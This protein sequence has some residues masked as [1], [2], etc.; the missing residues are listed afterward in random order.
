MKKK[1]LTDTELRSHW[2]GK[3]E[4]V[5][6][7]EEGTI[8]TP[9]ARDFLREHHITLS[10][11]N[12]AENSVMTRTAIPVRDGKAVYVNAQTGRELDQKGE[13]MTHLRGNLLV[14]KTHPRIE[15]RGRLDSLMAQ[16][17]GV[18]LVA[19]E[20]QP[21][22]AEE[23]QEL[24]D[25][26]RAILGAEVKD[27]PLPEM[28]LLGMSSAEIRYSSH[29]VKETLGIDHPIPDYRMGRMCVALNRLRTQVREVEL[30]AARA[31]IEDGRVEHGDIIEAL[32][33]LS[34]CV[35]ILFCR[36]LSG[37]YDR[38]DGI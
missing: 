11:V 38:G 24:L 37:Y 19:Q 17:L 6:T 31:F 5:C 33:R 26:V 27:E 7:V 10:V 35:Y 13:E 36:K 9:A 3:Q 32:N 29:H 2:K 15:F 25:C 8:L 21:Q 28:R 34:S 1:L 20:E 14:P 18:Q 16:M 22:I 12:G 23:L 4:Y 30:S